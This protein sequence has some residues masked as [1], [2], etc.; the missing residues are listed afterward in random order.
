M[1]GRFCFLAR[2]PGCGAISWALRLSPTSSQRWRWPPPCST[3]TEENCPTSH[4]SPPRD[5]LHCQNQRRLGVPHSRIHPPTAGTACAA[6]AWGGVSCGGGLGLARCGGIADPS[7]Y[8]TQPSRRSVSDAT[9]SP[10]SCPEVPQPLHSDSSVP[11]TTQK[12][13]SSLRSRDEVGR[14]KSAEEAAEGNVQVHQDCCQCQQ[15]STA[16]LSAKNLPS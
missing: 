3:S 7:P 16:R 2:R 11:G 12:V 8:V 5:Y 14:G 9:R 1:V 10:G 6:Q 13:S 4:G 15:H